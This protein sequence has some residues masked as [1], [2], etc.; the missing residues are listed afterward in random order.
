[1]GQ[2]FSVGLAKELVTLAWQPQLWKK[3]IAPNQLAAFH[4][5]TWL[6]VVG[7][8]LL[9]QCPM[10]FNDSIV[11]H[12]NALEQNTNQCFT[13]FYIM[14][15]QGFS[16]LVLPPTEHREMKISGICWTV[17]L[18]EDGHWYQMASR[19]LPILCAL[20][21]DV[22]YTTCK[23]CTST[24]KTSML[25]S[26]DRENLWETEV[27]ARFLKCLSPCQMLWTRH[28]PNWQPWR[29]RSMNCAND[30]SL[31]TTDSCEHRWHGTLP[32]FF[33]TF[34]GTPCTPIPAESYP[35]YLWRHEN[36]GELLS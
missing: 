36:S 29:A 30:S 9:L 28:P 19:A 12:C 2:E 1:M 21:T 5:S 23:G 24:L 27:W 33:R 4:G 25:N 35:R 26:E 14:L 17:M 20:E 3:T 6:L 15:H 34:S 31:F 13:E 18:H 11:H 22:N 10:I 8:W 7:F 16:Y 32:T